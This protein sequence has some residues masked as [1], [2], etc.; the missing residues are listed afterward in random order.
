MELRQC[1]ILRN[2]VY[3]LIA[4]F[5]SAKV[6]MFSSVSAYLFVCLL[7]AELH[8]NDSTDV[9]KIRC[10]GGTWANEESVRFWR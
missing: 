5:T 4:I 8:K 1:C 3:H 7:L 6:V 10:K 9:H 2:S